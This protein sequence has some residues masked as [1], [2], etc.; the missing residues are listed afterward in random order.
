[1]HSNHCILHLSPSSAIKHLKQ[2]AETPELNAV[3]LSE[4]FVLDGVARQDVVWKATYGEQLKL[5]RHLPKAQKSNESASSDPL[6]YQ[7]SA[8]AAAKRVSGMHH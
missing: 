3:F 5:K 2:A 4:Q 8:L 7:C 6:P 1:M